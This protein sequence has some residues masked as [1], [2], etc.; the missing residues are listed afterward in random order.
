MSHHI[1]VFFCPVAEADIPQPLTLWTDAQDIL[2]ER[3]ESPVETG[4]RST[5]SHSWWHQYILDDICRGLKIG[6]L[7]FIT[8][9]V[10]CLDRTHLE[11]A[12][13]ALD[14]VLGRILDGVPDLGPDIE[15]DRGTLWW[16]RQVPGV[17]SRFSA[18]DYRRALE[19]A[20][21]VYDQEI[22]REDGFDALVSF[23]S[24]IKTL[25]AAIDDCLSQDK[26]L[27]Y[28]QPQP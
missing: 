8:V 7:E 24:F 4:V 2:G 12:D 10:A 3:L 16:L 17:G 26:Y 23:F 21:A 14:K 11:E 28:I 9:E 22:G 6:G 13:R 1:P 5:V 18:D 27:L 19:T 25:R 20:Q 15:R